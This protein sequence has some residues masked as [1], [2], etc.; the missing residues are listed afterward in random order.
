MRTKRVFTS[1]MIALGVTLSNHALSIISPN[2]WQSN[3]AVAQGYDEETGIRIYEQVSP[4]VVAINSGGS[5]GS[6]SIIT[7]DGLILTN[8]HVLGAA[9]T[10][11]VTLSDGSRFPADVVGFAQKGLDLAVI[12]IRGARNLPTVSLASTGSVKVGQRAFAIGSPFGLEG[13][14]TVGIVSRID[15]RQG[16]IQT[17]AAINP[18]NSGGPLI[19]SQGEVI[20][21][22]T[23][24]VSSSPRSGN[25]GIGFS[26][27]V[28]RI[29]PFLT[30][31]RE[32]RAAS[33]AR[34]GRNPLNSSKPALPLPLDGSVVRG[35]LDRSDDIWLGD[36]SFYDI[37]RFEGEAGARVRLEMVS[38]TV[39][40]Y[41]ILIGPDGNG[42]AQD[43]DS[44][45]GSNARIVAT[46]PVDGTYTVLAN[47]YQGGQAGNYRLRATAI[48]DSGNLSFVNNDG[49]IL[50]E[51]G[52]LGPSSAVLPS[53]G[54]FY[55][56]YTFEG[57]RGQQVNLTLES[58]DFNTYLVL[59]DTNGNKIDESANVSTT[60][61][62]SRIN[63]TLPDTGTYTVVVNTYESS[64][65]GRYILEI[66]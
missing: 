56:S 40:S 31:V 4:A 37:Y 16:L 58:G 2:F 23:S 53:D 57:Q 27:P 42:I 26:I 52:V 3:Q 7:P 60:K 11:S 47:S 46:L 33:T 50:R 21:V 63:T 9:R 55:E 49:I 20:G 5:T 36:N 12:K 34:E 22:N 32:G 61:S 13:T 41:L 44:A 48:S 15:P 43:D 64:G 39:D 18:G 38:S 25:V 8:A 29:E 10:V 59:L 51:Q 28:E 45:G 6:G 14:F 30:A 66:R 24:I 35:S 1:V 54:S 19:N 17:D 62:I 65:G